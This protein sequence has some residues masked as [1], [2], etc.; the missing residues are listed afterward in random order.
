MKLDAKRFNFDIINIIVIIHVILVNICIY[1]D[2]VQ[3]TIVLHLI[4]LLLLKWIQ[5]NI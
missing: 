2:I 4:D 3:K 1:I 5:V